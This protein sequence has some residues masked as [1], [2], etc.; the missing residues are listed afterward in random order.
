MSATDSNVGCV[1]RDGLQVRLTGDVRSVAH[2]EAIKHAVADAIASMQP[3]DDN[4]VRLNVE[5][6]GYLDSY[7]LV[8]LVAVARRCHEAGVAFVIVG[9]SDE[10]LDLLRITKLDMVLPLYDAHFEPARPAA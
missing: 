3:G 8:A 2:R 7:L 9:A 6:A 4:T 5:T 10:L 1:E